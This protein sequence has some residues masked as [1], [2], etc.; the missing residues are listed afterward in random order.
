MAIARVQSI[1]TS[2]GAS[3][4]ATLVLTFGAATT[5]GNVVIVGV[6][7][8]SSATVKVTSAHG[9][10]MDIT[11]QGTN[12]TASFSN[13]IFMGIMSGADT[14]ITVGAVANARM[15][16]VAAEYSG[17]HIL[18]SDIPTNSFSNTA[19]P[20][21]S[22]ITNA[23]AN[24]LYVAVLGQK[25][26]NS[27]STN[28][29]WANTPTNSFNI[30]NQNS[31]STN[32]GSVDLAVAYLDSIVTTSTARNTSV[33]SAFGAINASGVLATFDELTTGGGIRTAGHGGLAA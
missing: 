2:T 8:T 17:V 20:N 5:S 22:A 1:T 27:G 33:V 23:N 13:H 21:V 12:P 24:S 29:G 32:S 26:F 6:N 9:I 30:V 31:T 15:V 3:A 19:T 11:P 28:S 16:A 10:F 7:V 25:G 18:P 14:A 4:A